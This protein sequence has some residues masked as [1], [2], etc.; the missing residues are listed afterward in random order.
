MR[1]YALWVVYLDQL[2]VALDRLVQLLCLL[3]ARAQIRW[4]HHP[5]RCNSVELVNRQF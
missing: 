5:H 2:G 1:E 4:A 3:Y